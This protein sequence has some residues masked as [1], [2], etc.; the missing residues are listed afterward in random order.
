LQLKFREGARLKKTDLLSSL[1]VSQLKLNQNN[2]IKTLYQT[3]KD[4]M[5][6]PIIDT[7]A[8]K[9]K[10]LALPFDI[11]KGSRKEAFRQRIQNCGIE[12]VG[13]KYDYIAGYYSDSDQDQKFPFI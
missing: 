11:N 12:V 13:I 1:T 6:P 9:K 5:N 3:L 8:A 7:D 2:E 10:L 4:A